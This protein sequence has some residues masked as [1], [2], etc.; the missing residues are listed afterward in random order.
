MP[1]DPLD[2]EILLGGRLSRKRISWRK[3]LLIGCG[4]FL[5]VLIA[6]DFLWSWFAHARLESAIAAI[7]TRGEPIDEK[8]FQPAQIPDSQNAAWYYQN[9]E[10]AFNMVNVKNWDW[11]TVIQTNDDLAQ[12][13]AE[14]DANKGALDWIAR[15]RNCNDAS[16]SVPTIDPA[17]GER[18]LTDLNLRRELANTLS[19]AVWLEMQNGRDDQAL[20]NTADII[21]LSDASQQSFPCVIDNLV[22]IGISA[23]GTNSI[24]SLAPRLNI[25]DT[26][27]A[28]RPT[29]ATR[30]QVLDLISLLNDERRYHEGA[31]R[32]LLGQRRFIL[33]YRD[34]AAKNA[35]I[36]G[37][38]WMQSPLIDGDSGIL[39]DFIGRQEKAYDQPDLQSAKKA[40][41]DDSWIRNQSVLQQVFHAYARKW[42]VPVSQRV[43]TY[44]RGLLD[45]R[46]AEV[47]LAIYLWRADHPGQWPNS[48][49]ELVPKYLPAVPLDPF[50]PIGA[51]VAYR[52]DSPAGPIIYSVA[53]DGVDDGGSEQ[54]ANPNAFRRSE[55]SMWE[56]K[57]FVYR[58]IPKVPT[59][60]S[61]DQ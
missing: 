35:G 26:P 13:N 40:L 10:N 48:L 9:A 7:R 33:D 32:S 41:P 14:V 45:R 28:T 19:M 50:S 55:P 25:I 27:A 8:D 42:A 59:T 56:M 3:L 2:E 16:W 20:Q 18:H 37:F 23:L 5:L 29:G 51:E 60:R 22:S 47:F 61:S 21:R 30:Q 24:P 52:P 49:R 43:E 11:W 46:A 44:F 15:A 4:S 6:L 57:D 17:T 1:L 54:A 53:D 12:L 36:M 39:L 34:A 58:L 38:H 31:K